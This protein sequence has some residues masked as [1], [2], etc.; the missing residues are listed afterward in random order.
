MEKK[1]Y[2]LVIVTVF[3]VIGASF[4]DYSDPGIM[5]YRTLDMW[6][7]DSIVRDA[8]QSKLESESTNSNMIFI[9]K[10]DQGNDSPSIGSLIS[11]PAGSFDDAI[12]FAANATCGDNDRPNIW[13]KTRTTSAWSD[14]RY[15][16][17][18]MWLKFGDFDSLQFVAMTDSWRIWTQGTLLRYTL[19][20]D[21]TTS[22]GNLDVSINGHLNEWLYVTAVFDQDGNQTLSVVSADGLFD[23][24]SSAT[25]TSKLLKET[26]GYIYI[27]SEKGV[28]RAFNGAMDCLRISDCQ[29]Q[30]S[31]AQLARQNVLLRFAHMNVDPNNVAAQ[32]TAKWCASTLWLGIEHADVSQA[33]IDLVNQRLDDMDNSSKF[34]QIPQTPVDEGE[35]PTLYWALPNLCRILSNNYMRSQLTSA[36]KTSIENVLIDFVTERDFY[37]DTSTNDIYIYDI[38]NSM[39]H[40]WLR[41]TVFLTA[42]Q[43][44]KSTGQN[45][46]DD[47]YTAQEHYDG[48]NAHMK[49]KIQRMAGYGLDPEIG[50]PGYISITLESIFNIRDLCEDI[51]LRD[52]ADTYISLVLA[53]AGC[54]S[55]EG[56]RGGGK[57]RSYKSAYSYDGTKDYLRWWTHILANT[58][59]SM[60][61][62]SRT[63]VGTC[64]SNY[65]M[66]DVVKNL[67]TDYDDRS[68][69][70]V[71]RRFAAGSHYV[72]Y[73][74]PVY[75]F[76]FPQDIRR[77]TYGTDKYVFGSFLIDEDGGNSKYVLLNTQNQWM[78]MVCRANPT[79]SR[80]YFQTRYPDDTT[81]SDHR[82]LNAMQYG[83][84]ML[85][86][87]QVTA[88]NYDLYCFMSHDF[89]A[90]RVEPDSSTNYWLFSKNSDSSVYVALKAVDATS[91]TFYDIDVSKSVPGYGDP[92]LVKF[93]DNTT[94][95]AFQTA[96][97]SSY[98]SFA[99]FQTAVKNLTLQANGANEVE[100]VTLGG[101]NLKMYRD[102]SDPKLDNSTYGLNISR[103]YSGNYLWNDTNG[104][105]SINIED[106]DGNGLLLDFNY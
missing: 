25:H 19:Y 30:Q 33:D 52:L 28:R 27:A 32:E 16:K 29:Q 104:D 43:Y 97:A 72:E 105:V 26:D 82:D 1:F 66:P 34:D 80:V 13:G 39:N 17:V 12:S 58:P 102:G 23:Q 24:S 94:I 45:I 60:G 100:F 9:L 73:D 6:Q 92:M 57:T 31:A 68:F 67:A 101:R 21:D 5:D 55:F 85:I 88:A 36:A 64:M 83:A 84:A 41:K 81:T 44:F 106:P 48:W 49:R 10:D 54:E 99:D 93:D 14:N 86:K 22:S 90:N 42:S 87:R 2:F 38:H 18:E 53:D 40:D 89:R 20:F 96:K 50:S 65:I 63:V 103:T 56:V 47:N 91:S 4:A 61:T 37:S 15:V 62:P 78:G 8:S 7:M 79:Y 51:V 76:D 3:S 77:H 35:L 74:V 70:H 75:Y 59:T 69:W 46:Y 95:C 11:G 71:S 98:N